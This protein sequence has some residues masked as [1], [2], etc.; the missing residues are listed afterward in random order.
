PIARTAHDAALIV[1]AM[2]GPDPHD[3]STQ[4]AP[5]VD[6]AAALAATPDLRGT[7]ITALAPERFPSYTEADVTRATREAAIEL[8]RLGA[9]VAG[10]EA[11][12]DLEAFAAANGR[13]IA[14]EAWAFHRGY[15]EDPA[16]DIDPWVRRRVIGGK[17]ITAA[18]YDELLAKR[19][20]EMATF[21]KWMR[22]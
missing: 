12:L 2:A 6:F 20:R 1:V 15:I 18:E 22:G 9:T 13:I 4:A 10:D 3:A 11:P 19:R 8:G 21:A 7:R 17:A 5:R 16:L 14:A